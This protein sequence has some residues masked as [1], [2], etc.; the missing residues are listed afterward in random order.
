MMAAR[1]Q[2]FD[3]H[4][5][6]NAASFARNRIVTLL[7]NHLMH[8]QLTP[9]SRGKGD[10]AVVAATGGGD[11]A[12]NSGAGATSVSEG[13]K[14]G[15]AG[16]NDNAEGEKGT[17]VGGKGAEQGPHEG[18][19]AGDANWL[20]E[21]LPAALARAFLSCHNDFAKSEIGFE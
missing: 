13:G 11:G 20:K 6:G 21:Q 5:G 9:S 1:S 18:D 7:R 4:G 10:G 2:V 16:G 19:E 15:N 3:G 14:E 17:S 8:L 12:A